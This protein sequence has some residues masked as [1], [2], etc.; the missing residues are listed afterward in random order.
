M[1]KKNNQPYR[2]VTLI[3][4]L[5]NGPP[6]IFSQTM[7]IIFQKGRKI[8]S[9]SSLEYGSFFPL[10]TSYLWLTI[11]SPYIEAFVAIKFEGI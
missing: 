7:H 10:F 2:A 3:S 9:L 6:L 8:K 11:R 5:I 4:H 1:Q